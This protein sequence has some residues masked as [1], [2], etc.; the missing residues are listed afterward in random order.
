[1]PPPPAPGGEGPGEKPPRPPPTGGGAS[2][3]APCPPSPR[4]AARTPCTATAPEPPTRRLPS[5]RTAH[6]KS[7]RASGRRPSTSDTPRRPEI[8]PG[9]PSRTWGNRVG[10]P[11]HTIH[12]GV[13]SQ[14][15]RHH[16][17]YVA[18]PPSDVLG[19]DDD[20]RY[21]ASDGETSRGVA[22]DAA[23][24]RDLVMGT[25]TQIGPRLGSRQ[26]RR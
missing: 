14:P 22:G 21:L 10:P 1:M 12:G 7:R 16:G 9:T 3:A 17:L 15:D 4:S 20:G 11:H 19:R 13:R 18:E 24:H 6:T 25:V 5:A 26:S 2:V 23:G 8:G